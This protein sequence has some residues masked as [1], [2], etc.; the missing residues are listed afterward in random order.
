MTMITIPMI[1]LIWIIYGWFLKTSSNKAFNWSSWIFPLLVLSIIL[2]IDFSTNYTA[3][4]NLVANDGISLRGVWSHLFISDKNWSVSTF[5]N[6]YRLSSYTSLTLM[7]LLIVS[8][9]YGRYK[10]KDM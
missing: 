7:F 10:S 5:Y 2:N 8:L 6:Y 1:I 4:L 3:S 9:I